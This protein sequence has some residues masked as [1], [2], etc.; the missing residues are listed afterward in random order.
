MLLAV[1]AGGCIILTFPD[2][3]AAGTFGSQAL[4]WDDQSA[5]WHLQHGHVLQTLIRLWDSRVRLP[6]ALRRA[7]SRP[8]AF[9]VNLRPCCLEPHV[10]ICPD[11]D[12]IYLANRREIVEWAQSKGCVVHFPAGEKG[13]LKS[14]VLIQISK[15][16]GSI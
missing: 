5:K 1:K 8:G 4:G 6:L 9:L 12:A 16:S 3:V 10:E 11:I 15:P 2:M 7:A 14:N 13:P